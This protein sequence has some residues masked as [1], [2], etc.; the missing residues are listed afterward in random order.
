MPENL[1]RQLKSRKEFDD[2]LRYVLE[3]RRPSTEVSNAE[4]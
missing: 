4:L 2:L 1:M 3:V